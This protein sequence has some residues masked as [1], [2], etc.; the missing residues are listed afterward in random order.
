MHIFAG[1]L[2]LTIRTVPGILG[3]SALN[4]IEHQ[5]CDYNLKFFSLSRL[6]APLSKFLVTFIFPVVKPCDLEFPT[7]M[8]LF[9]YLLYSRLGQTCA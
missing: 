4:H 3:N 2:V 6:N 5:V 9:R 1:I 7:I 8:I